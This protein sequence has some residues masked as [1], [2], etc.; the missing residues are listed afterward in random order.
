MATTLLLLCIASTSSSRQGRF[1]DPEEPL[2][3]AGAREAARFR[4]GDRFAARAVR[5]PARAAAETA[6]AMGLTAHVEPALAD[7]D[8][9][10]WTGLPFDEIAPQAMA[11]WLADPAQGTPGGET[12]E[13]ARQRI[14]AWI[15]AMAG[16]D[17]PVCAITHPMI[18]R[19]A[20]AHALGM[21]FSAALAIDL[22]PLSRAELSFNRSWRL[23]ALGPI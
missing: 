3:A 20:L 8:H 15:D 2:D 9:G 11:A 19:A 7:L 23:R 6:T 16:R 10:S 14:G 21:P 4:P 13:Q 17:A 12:M 18:V 1:P 22:A 5:S